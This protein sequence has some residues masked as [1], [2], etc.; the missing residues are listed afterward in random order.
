MNYLSDK[1]LVTA[2]KEVSA[3]EIEQTKARLEKMGFRI[4]TRII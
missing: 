1:Y 2:E 4:S 3:E